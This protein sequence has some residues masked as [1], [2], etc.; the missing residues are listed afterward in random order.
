MWFYRAPGREEHRSGTLLKLETIYPDA[1]H[2]E[3]NLMIEIFGLKYWV[4][5]S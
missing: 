4:L 5:Q 2:L 1:Q 3:I